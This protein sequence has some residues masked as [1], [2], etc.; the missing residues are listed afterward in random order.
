[1]DA[2]VADAALPAVA[3]TKSTETVTLARSSFGSA[4]LS[5]GAVLGAMQVSAFG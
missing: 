3:A 2:V 1:M 4:L 5:G